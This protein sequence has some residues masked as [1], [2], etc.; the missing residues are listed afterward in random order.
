MG[1]RIR[2]IGIINPEDVH[3]GDTIE[4]PPEVL[5]FV[6]I[7]EFSNGLT[8][9]MRIGNILDAETVWVRDKKEIRNFKTG[10]TFYF[11]VSYRF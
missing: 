9:K 7:E 1:E 3:F 8:G 11:K 5:D 6:W 10:Q 4:S 2:R